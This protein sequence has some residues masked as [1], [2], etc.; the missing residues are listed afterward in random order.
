MTA[1]ESVTNYTSKTQLSYYISISCNLAYRTFYQSFRLSLRSRRHSSCVYC[2]L[3]RK[4]SYDPVIIRQRHIS[5]RNLE[6]KR[7]FFSCFQINSLK[8][9][10]SRNRSF[11]H[12]FMRKIQL[13]NFIPIF[14]PYIFNFYRNFYR[15]T[16]FSSGYDLRYR[17]IESRMDTT[18]HL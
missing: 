11:F 5:R 15:L 6:R 10:Q 9:F 8:S 7:F 1:S 2:F 4:Y 17:I 13:D 12:T 16:D 3:T 14:L 18:L